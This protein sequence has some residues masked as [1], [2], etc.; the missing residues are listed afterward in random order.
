MKEEAEGRQEGRAASG[1]A[2]AVPAVA[3]GPQEGVWGQSS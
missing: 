3:I 2:P 1:S